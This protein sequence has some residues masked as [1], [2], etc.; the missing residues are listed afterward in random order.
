MCQQLAHHTVNG[1]NMN[2]GDILASGTISGPTEDSYGSMLEL[3]WKG[4]KPI[5]MNDGSTRLFL[6]DGDT[7]TLRGFATKDGVRVG[8]GESVTKIL[9]AK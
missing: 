5:P 8:F 7:N 6:Q 9:P 4:T 3:G 1:C 2:I